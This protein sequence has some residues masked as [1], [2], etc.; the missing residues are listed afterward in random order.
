[1]RGVLVRLADEGRL[2]VPVAREFPLAEAPLALRM[3]AE[4]HPGGAFALVP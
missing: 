4:G 2:A 3:L 1:M